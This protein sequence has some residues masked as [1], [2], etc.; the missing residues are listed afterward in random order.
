MSQQL[1]NS[2]AVV[3]NAEYRCCVRAGKHACDR[4]TGTLRRGARAHVRASV[5][6]LAPLLEHSR[7]ARQQ[8]PHSVPSSQNRRVCC[9]LRLCRERAAA[10]RVGSYVAPHC[11]CHRGDGGISDAAAAGIVRRPDC[12]QLAKQVLVQ[13]R[14]VL[15]KQESVLCL[16]ALICT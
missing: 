1:V 7:V 11:G 10:G 6:A 14:R 2:N 12:P 13:S 8:A 15:Q 5:R 3:G 4:A 9:C 16:C